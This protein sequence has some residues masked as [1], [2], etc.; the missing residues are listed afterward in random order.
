NFYWNSRY[1]SSRYGCYCYWCPYVNSWYYWCAPQSCY[2]PISYITVVPPTVTVA[3]STVTVAPATVAVTPPT[4]A[5]S[6]PVSGGPAGPG[7]HAPRGPSGPGAHPSQ[8][9]QL[10]RP[11][12]GSPGGFFFAPRYDADRTVRHDPWRADHASTPVTTSP[13]LMGSGRLSASWISVF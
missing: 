2:Y 11:A 8:P 4:V 12:P 5:V 6:T 13:A 3:P 9:L 1:W 10:S 7:R